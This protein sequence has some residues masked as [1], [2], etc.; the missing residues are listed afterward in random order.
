MGHDSV[1]TSV[2]GVS[3][4]LESNRDIAEVLREFTML[5]CFG[6]ML[7]NSISITIPG[8][9][10]LRESSRD[11]AEVFEAAGG[12]SECIKTMRKLSPGDNSN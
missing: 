6:Y 12:S 8:V 5:I 10:E 7:G 2:L 3:E 11:I 9:S 1:F 4:M